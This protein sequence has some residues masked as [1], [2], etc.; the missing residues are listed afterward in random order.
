MQDRASAVGTPV[1]RRPTHGPGRAGFP[2]PVPMGP[3]TCGGVSRPAGRG[4]GPPVA[5]RSRATAAARGWPAVRVTTLGVRHTRLATRYQP[6]RGR[7]PPDGLQDARSTLRPS[8]A[9][10]SSRRRR[11]GRQTRDGWVARP[12][13]TGTL[14]RH[15]T[16]S[17][18][19]ATIGIGRGLATPLLPHHRAYGSR[20]TAV[21]LR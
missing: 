2:Q 8:C 7:G 11:P 12:D 13:P 10:W 18:L 3:P 21:R 6:F 19:G 9:S 17:F 1:T 14:T 16:P 15:E 5:L 20:T 4:L